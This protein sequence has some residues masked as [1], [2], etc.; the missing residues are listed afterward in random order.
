MKQTDE[1]KTE[2]K[3][4]LRPTVSVLPDFL[5]SFMDLPKEAQRKVAEFFRKFSTNPTSP[6]INY[7]TLGGVTDDKVR[8]VRIDGVYR[9][10]VVTPEKG[11]VY[12]LARVDREDDL[13]MWVKSLR[14]SRGEGSDE[15][16]VTRLAENEGRSS[17][18]PSIA[19]TKGLLAH[20]S[21]EELESFGVP[22]ILLPSVRAITDPDGYDLLCDFI[23]FPDTRTALKF[24]AHGFPVEEVRILYNDAMSLEVDK[25]AVLEFTEISRK[26]R[27]KD[28]EAWIETITQLMIRAKKDASNDGLMTKILK[29]YKE[30][31][32]N[33]A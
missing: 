19:T 4:V 32:K 20:C 7:E 21:D 30:M 28:G 1:K 10:I 29:I 12:L 16:I 8:S 31:R 18:D 2:T 23:K 27:Q 11:N 13:Y 6:G 3:T 5:S 24:L 14:F 15:V 26:E 25:Q 9:A 22:L 33:S 17:R